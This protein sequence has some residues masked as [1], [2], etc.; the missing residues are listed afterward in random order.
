VAT[1]TRNKLR[2]ALQLPA[3]S[4]AELNEFPVSVEVLQQ[5]ALQRSAHLKKQAIDALARQEIKAALSFNEEALCTLM[6]APP[7]PGLDVAKQQIGKQIDQINR[8]DVSNA[9]K[10][11]SAEHYYQSRGRRSE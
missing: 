10:A 7:A 4:A 2:V 5:A 8:G 6:E 1:G 3:V 11:A 9:R